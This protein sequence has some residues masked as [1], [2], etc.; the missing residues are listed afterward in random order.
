MSCSGSFTDSGKKQKCGNGVFADAAVFS[1]HP[2]KHIACGEGGMITTNSKDIYDK[3]I[4]LR[5][6][7]ITKKNMQNNHGDWYYEMKKLGYNYRLTDI[8][9]AL[10]I[11]QLKK[12]YEGVKKRN[13]IAKKY[14][15]Y[16]KG[17]IKFQEL[18]DGTLNAHHLFIIEIDR[19]K[20][21]YEFL[22]KN[23]I[24]SQI[25]YI[26]IHT[27]P[28]YKSIG[29]EEANLENS[30][31][32]YN[33]CLSLPMYPSLTEKEQEYVISKVIEFINE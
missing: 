17:K 8:Q 20:K 21:L 5:T 28:Y 11:S 16:F 29:Y 13:E 6:H 10:G 27:L 25:H 33:N 12:N 3:L 23:N 15:K 2:V 19:R 32:Y 9:A 18:T 24:Y 31:K 30:E 4:L 7:G 1:F 26:P 14:K 22:K